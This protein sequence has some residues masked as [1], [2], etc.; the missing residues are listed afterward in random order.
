MRKLHV[1][2]YA[3]FLILFGLLS[4]LLRESYIL[5]IDR[6]IN[7]WFAGIDLPVV[8]SLMQVVSCLG[9]TIPAV[10]MVSLVV[11][12]L[13]FFRM[14]LEALF[15]IVLPSLT[16][17]LTWLVKVLVD[18][19]R[20]GEALLDNGGLSF[21]SGHVSY[22]V[23]F[24][25]FL[26]YLLPGMIKRHIIVTALKAVIVILI[27]LMMI[28]RVYLGEHWPSDVLGSIIFSG[29]ILAPSVV[30]YNNM[31]VRRKDARTA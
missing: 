28:S 20:P 15:V 10:I 9:D 22:I 30:L 11:I 19:P 21:P 3:I 16:A 1:A 13:L 23:V 12:I 27:L 5:P 14:R 25:V 26:F 7:D 6:V 24:L 2:I 4:Y 29:L 18:R 17:L 8:H 31:V